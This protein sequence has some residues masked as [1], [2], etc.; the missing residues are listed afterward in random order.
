MDDNNISNKIIPK[1]RFSE[2]N[3]EWVSSSFG[4]IFQRVTRK[5][6]ENNQNILTISAQSGLIS[7]DK[8]FTKLVSAKDVRG[9]YLLHKGD[10]AYN[11]SYS[12][13]YPMGAIKQL[14]KEEKGVVSTLYICFR[15]KNSRVGKFYEQFF[16]A[17]RL[18]SEIQKIAQEGARN[19]GLLNMSVIDFFKMSMITPSV[20]EQEKIA[21]FLTIVDDKIY[22]IGRRIDLLMLY[23]K[24][25]TQALFKKDIRFSDEN[26]KTY[27]D[28][29]AIRIEHILSE[30][31]EKTSSTNQYVTLSSTSRGLF[32]QD[33]YFKKEIASTD[34]TGYKILRKHQLVFSPQNLWLGNINVNLKYDIG[35][36]SPSYKIFNIRNADVRFVN[37]LLSSPRMLFEYAQASEQGASVVRRNLDMGSFM[38]IRIDLP[39]LLEQSRI[40]D[41]ISELE[42]KIHV[43]ESKLQQ[44]KKFKEALLQKMFV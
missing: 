19:H 40:A 29:Q 1:L 25:V 34:N 41:Y 22:V 39:S 31:S 8:Y 3:S 36:V 9:Y 15:P 4:D 12:K 43:E 33:E 26:N 14:T 6:T 37:N 18:N 44:I 42:R 27:P 11:K 10:F 28:W 5:N 24:G 13:G 38:S 30:V 35:I 20:E 7:Q 23:K 2:F 17:G 32:R 16:E 21:G